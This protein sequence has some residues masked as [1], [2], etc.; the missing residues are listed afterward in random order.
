MPVD[1]TTLAVGTAILMHVSLALGFAINGQHRAFR[2]AS[3]SALLYL[4]FVLIMV[5]ASQCVDNP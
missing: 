5:L 2:Q 1:T 4:A 3:V